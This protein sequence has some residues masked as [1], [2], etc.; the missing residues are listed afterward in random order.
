MPRACEPS[1]RSHACLTQKP[2]CTSKPPAVCAGG[3]FFRQTVFAE[4]RCDEFCNFC[5]AFSVTRIPTDTCKRFQRQRAR[6]VKQNRKS[7]H[8]AALAGLVLGMTG[9]SSTPS[10]GSLK[11]EPSSYDASL[12]AAIEGVAREDASIPG[13]IAAVSAPRLGIEWRGATGSLVR[14]GTEPLKPTDAFRIASVTKIYTAAT[15]IRLIESGAF[16]LY[17]R[18]EPLIS[19]KTR[20]A[21]LS[22]GYDLPALTV[23]HLL[24]H[25]S[26]LYDTSTSP[27]FAA[28]VTKDPMHRWTRDEQ[29]AFA[30]TYGKPAAAPGA[31]YNYSES[32]YLV[33]AEIIER[34]SG[35]SMEDA[36]TS[37][38]GLAD[39][40]L[41]ETY[42]ESL[43]PTP[44][45]ERRAHQY[46]GDVDATGFDPSLDLFGGGGLVSTVS[47]LVGFIRPLMQGELFA[48]KSTMA[49]ALQ[50]PPTKNN[51]LAH[52]PLLAQTQFG[53]RRC[54]SHAGY[55]GVELIYCPDIDVAVAIS[56]GQ[57]EPKANA[58]RSSL[59]KIAAVIEQAERAKGSGNAAR[60]D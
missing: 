33:L 15:V 42:F 52:A 1:P 44:S 22:D 19:E 31:A 47:D 26:G 43:Q 48:G 60:A 38:L 45:G 27:E 51:A 16:G 28:A 40:G 18:I 49:M 55:W 21:L 20:A 32:S 34:A 58:W 30:M 4:Q 41:D 9:C 10:L 37:L 57:A 11:V 59:D 14:G 8:F 54:W 3:D 50:I 12:Q 29:I 5:I 17:D 39:H 24:T 7:W 6:G 46:V 23:Y 56:W 25:T 36:I 2:G 53:Q 35:R 13:V